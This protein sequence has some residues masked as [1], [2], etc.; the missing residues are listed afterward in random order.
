MSKKDPE[1]YYLLPGMGGAA[2]RQKVKS[3]LVWGIMGGIFTGTLLAMIFYLV[4][5]WGRYQP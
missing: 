4:S 2:W 3:M 5:Y 1:R